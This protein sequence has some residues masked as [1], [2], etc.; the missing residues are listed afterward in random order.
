MRVINS[1]QENGLQEKTD[2]SGKMGVKKVTKDEYGKM[3]IWMRKAWSTR[4]R[5][6]LSLMPQE[7]LDA[8]PDKKGTKRRVK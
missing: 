3:N 8:E 6:W 2:K 1:K 5:R 4:V 7:I